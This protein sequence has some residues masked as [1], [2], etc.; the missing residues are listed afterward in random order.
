M[1]YK[2]NYIEGPEFHFCTVY[3]SL[4]GIKKIV[5]HFGSFYQPKRDFLKCVSSGI[6]Q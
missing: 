2:E 1:S 3:I 5:S 6:K 4:W